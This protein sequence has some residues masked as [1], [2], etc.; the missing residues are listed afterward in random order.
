MRDLEEARTNPHLHER[1][2]L[3][4]RTHE[5]MGEIVLPGSPIRYSDYPPGEITFFPAAGEH[6]RQVFSTWLGLSDEELD[7]LSAQ[8]II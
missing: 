6:N 5:E 2:M 1:G 8:S 4:W 7:G 3:Q